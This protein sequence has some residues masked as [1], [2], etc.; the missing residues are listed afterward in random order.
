MEQLAARVRALRDGV[1]ATAIHEDADHALGHAS[2]IEAMGLVARGVRK[3]QA[4]LV[5]DLAELGD[6]A[7]AVI[8]EFEAADRRLAGQAGEP[9]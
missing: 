1:H 2:L 3:R 7:A 4:R 5:A 9:R 8:D 6:H